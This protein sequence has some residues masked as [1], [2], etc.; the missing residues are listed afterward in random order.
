MSASTGAA[1]AGG[2]GAAGGGAAGG[3]TASGGGA[4]GSGGSGGSSSSVGGSDAPDLFGDLSAGISNILSDQGKFNLDRTAALLQV[5]DRESRLDLVE[6][7]LQAVMLRATRQ[8]QIEA[9]VVEVELRDEFSAGI[10]W[11]AVLG[12][13]TI[14]SG[15]VTVRGWR[16]PDCWA[17]STGAVARTHTIRVRC[18]DLPRLKFRPEGIPQIVQR[19]YK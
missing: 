7:Y 15:C 18:T 5:T 10:N 17:A 8:V 12:S 4:Q 11:K 9:K 2:G 13:L 14:P 6:Q 3:P 19:S 16:A 1:G